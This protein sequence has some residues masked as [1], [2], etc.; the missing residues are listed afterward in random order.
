MGLF[1]AKQGKEQANLAEVFPP[2]TPFRLLEAV[3]QGVVSGGFGER[4][5]VLVNVSPVTEPERVMQFGVWA[6]LADQALQAEPG[7]LPAIVT[8]SNSSGLWQFAPH[9]PEPIQVEDPETGEVSEQ[10][11]RVNAA[12]HLDLEGGATDSP[13]GPVSDHSAPPPPE[14]PEGGHKPPVPVDP[15]SVHP[16]PIDESQVFQPGQSGH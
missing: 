1:G 12:A 13:L 15:P 8:L 16:T 9:G 2:G 3:D 6:S 7:E 14:V 11:M 4:R 5:L 10:P